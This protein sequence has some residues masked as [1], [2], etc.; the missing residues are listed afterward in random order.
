MPYRSFGPT[1]TPVFAVMPR[2]QLLP[3]LPSHLVADITNAARKVNSPV[4]AEATSPSCQGETLSFSV[5]ACFQAFSVHVHARSRQDQAQKGIDIVFVGNYV[6]DGVQPS[7]F[8]GYQM[9]FA[10]GDRRSRSC[11]DKQI[12]T[13]SRQFEPRAA[14]SH[15]H[16][17]P[18][19]LGLPHPAMNMQ[20]Q[21]DVRS[22]SAPFISK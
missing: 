19:D 18:T 8:L 7:N 15:P 16:T 14:V 21:C 3:S 1:V 11:F 20:V 22:P 4:V 9:S 6:W 13:A 10:P 5:M 2:R 17:A 12:Y